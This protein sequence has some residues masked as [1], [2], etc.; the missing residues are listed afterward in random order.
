MKSR[1]STVRLAAIVGA[2]G[3]AVGSVAIGLTPAT[4]EPAVTAVANTAINNDTV[5]HDTQGNPIKAQGGNVLKVGPT[6]YWVGTAMDPKGSAPVAPAKAVNLYKS[7][8]LENWEFVRAL[9][10]QWDN[11]LDDDGTADVPNAQSPVPGGDPAGD[12]TAGKWLGRPQLARHP[13]GRFILTLEVGG[14]RT[15]TAGGLGNATGFFESTTGIEGE[16][17]YLQKQY[18]DV[19]SSDPD[20][21][22]RGDG[23]LYVDGAN[24]YLVYVG[25]SKTW[26]NV[27]GVRVAPLSADWRTI[28]PHTHDDTVAEY[29]APAITKIGST[30]YMFASKKRYWDGTDTYYRTS[31]DPTNWTGR[32]WTKMT[33][34]PVKEGS[35]NDLVRSYG[36]QFEQVFPVTSTDGTTT[37]YLYNGDRYSQ[38]FGGKDPAPAGI[39]RN[40]WY[41]VTFDAAGVPTLHGAT[42]VDVNAAAGTLSWNPVANGGFGQGAPF[43]TYIPA[44]ADSATYDPAT[45]YRF[46]PRWIVS[47]TTAAVKVQERTDAADD[48]Q[49]KFQG[50]TAFSASVAQEVGLERGSYRISFKMK[51]SGGFNDAYLF[52][53]NHGVGE[54]HATVNTAANSWTTV[55]LDFD[56]S[57]EKVRFGF[58]ANG[59]AGKWL[60]LDDV[61]ITKR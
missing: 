19:T 13:D 35:G 7:T 57:S 1:T 14:N 3:V 20:G 18:V 56:V 50:A 22:T 48:R 30:Y 10:T 23:S 28:L 60:S 8:D 36:T 49:L 41:P 42:Q 52:V 4:A 15:S 2:I 38:F 6:Y 55:S 61:V 27:E 59:A 29:E 17:T 39:G 26:R 45:A 47:G 31:T 46:V 12:L 37:S 16:F 44:L 51:G 32:T 34:N 9:V 25:D 11:D 24:A 54:Q 33:T 21:L 58:Y 40:A 43:E 53:K 5:W